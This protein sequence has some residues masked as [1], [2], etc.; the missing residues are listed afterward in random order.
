VQAA[1]VAKATSLPKEATKEQR[2][3]AAREQSPDSGDDHDAFFDQGDEG[4]YHGGP[5]SNLP[6]PPESSEPI[7]PAIPPPARTPEQRERARRNA[8]LVAGVVLAGVVLVLLGLARMKSNSQ[9]GQGSEGASAPPLAQQPPP[10]P[11]PPPPPPLPVHSAA[12]DAAPASPEPA[13]APPAPAPPPPAANIA[14]PAV[15]KPAPV[16]AAPPP[17]PLPPAPDL[18]PDPLA[19]EP[20]DGPRSGSGGKPPT[21][22]Y[23]IDEKR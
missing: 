11:A 16:P 1:S 22:S 13:P 8:R 19:D 6:P 7:E 5:N 9:S 21:A 3:P 15:K 14:P 18:M 12:P 4:T 20:G 2:E 17:A 23:P 10:P